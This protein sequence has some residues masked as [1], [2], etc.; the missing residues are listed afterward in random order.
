MKCPQCDSLLKQR[1]VE[2]EGARQKALSYQCSN[3]RCLYT[4]FERESSKKIIAELKAKELQL[5]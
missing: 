4:T 2:V 3:K 5:K 1:K